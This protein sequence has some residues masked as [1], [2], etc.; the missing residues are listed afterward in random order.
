MPD[1][2]SWGGVQA[3]E[4]PFVAALRGLGVVDVREEIYVY[5]EKAGK[6]G[7]PQ[8]VERVWRTARKFSRIV[9]ENDFDVLHLN[10]AF[11][12][13]TLLRD[14]T[15]LMMLPQKKNLKVFLKLHGSENSVLQS[16]GLLDRSLRGKMLARVDGFGVLSSEEKRNFIAAGV[17]ERKLFVV[18]NAVRLP[19]SL[20]LREFGRKP[21]RLLFAS[22]FVPTKGLL[23]TVNAAIELRARN[24]DVT[25]DCL[26]DGGERRAG[27]DLVDSNNAAGYIR[28]HGYVTEA[29][30]NEF[31]VQSDAL[32]FPTVHAEG[33]PMVI[34][35]AMAHGLPIITTK[36]RA[37]ADYLREPENVLWTTRSDLTEKIIALMQKPDLRQQMSVNNRRLAAQFTAAEIAPE[38]LA[39]YRELITR[40]I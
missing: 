36:I 8:R 35:N 7:L 34:F 37:A 13:R 28:F 29:T 23:A 26:G 21:F 4:P 33:F 20:P 27:E 12:R 5:G 3:C 38:Y 15:T 14:V 1:P 18:K 22:R 24:F 10:T 17:D 11:D 6:I 19:P 39:I 2:D 16:D 9:G 32:V 40:K 25:L 31:C 30:V